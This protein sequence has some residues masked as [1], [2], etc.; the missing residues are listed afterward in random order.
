MANL[1]GRAGNFNPV[2]LASNQTNGYTRVGKAAKI[3]KAKKQL[4]DYY[5][6]LGKLDDAYSECLQMTGSLNDLMMKNAKLATLTTILPA[7]K[8]C[9]SEQSASSASIK[10]SID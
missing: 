4:I 10:V 3:G 2:L 1:K 6:T 7:T 5:T 8:I 9:W